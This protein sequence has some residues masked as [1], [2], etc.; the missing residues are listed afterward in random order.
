MKII[1]KNTLLVNVALFVLINFYVNLSNAQ[2][3]KN[4]PLTA[5]GTFVVDLKPDGQNKIGDI[6][7][8]KYV[9]Q[10]IFKGDLDATSKVDMLSAGSDNGSGA[11]V[12]LESIAGTLNGRNGTFVLMHSGTRT[13]TS[14]QLTVIVV[15]GC[16]TGD[17]IGLEGKLTINIVG[18]EH[19]YI[20]EYSL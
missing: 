14:Q 17:L 4:Y 8:G 20:F 2:T 11:Y 15:P 12:A 19:S 3:M 18:K 1:S 9:I 5:K 7:F 10:K 13:K 16:S 6:T